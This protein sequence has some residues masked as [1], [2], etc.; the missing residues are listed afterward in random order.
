MK[1][2]I[3]LFKII[4]F[5]A[6]V[7]YFLGCTQNPNMVQDQ[8]MEEQGTCPEPV[9]NG[10]T[11]LYAYGDSIT[12]GSM[13][14]C[15]LILENWAKYV[16][17]AQGYNFVDNAV[18]GSSMFYY[19]NYP[20]IM[21]DAWPPGS[22]VTFMPGRG[23]SL[24]FGDDPDYIADYQ[25]AIVDILNRAKGLPITFYLIGTIKC[26]NNY[27]CPNDPYYIQAAINAFNMVPSSNIV[28][29]DFWN[30]FPANENNM[31]GGIPGSVHPNM[32]GMQ[33]LSQYF[34]GVMQ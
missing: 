26:A 2:V 33:W 22:I 1:Y 34:I 4:G 6:L 17:I 28:Y 21:T 29:V 12:Q 30:N 5:I 20:E 32:I 11:T 8:D 3:S 27:G 15:N 10:Q 31:I 19:N 7:G 24:H 25:Q 18:G 16:A 13:Y 23:D 14:D 9:T